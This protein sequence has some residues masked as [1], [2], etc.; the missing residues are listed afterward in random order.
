VIF[1]RHGEPLPHRDASEAQQ[2]LAR[3][4]LGGRRATARKC[5]TKSSARRRWEMGNF[6]SEKIT[7]VELLDDVLRHVEANA[8][9]STTK[10]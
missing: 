4:P 10:I 5:A 1:C 3:S 2:H 8:T 9:E 6:S 7:C